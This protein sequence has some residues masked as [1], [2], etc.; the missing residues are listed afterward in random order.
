[1]EE[2]VSL[3]LDQLVEPLHPGNFAIRHPIGPLN[4][5]LKTYLKL[6]P[7]LP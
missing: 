5:H 4:Y 2:D 6:S 3:V 7:G 1:M